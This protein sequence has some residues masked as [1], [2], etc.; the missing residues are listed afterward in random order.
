MA[1]RVCLKDHNINGKRV[2]VTLVETEPNRNKTSEE[3]AITENKSCTVLVS[4]LPEETTEYG[5]HIHFQKKKNGGGEIKT[6]TLVPEKKVATV[7][8]EDIEGSCLPF[9]FRT[10]PKKCFYNTK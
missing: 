4:D 10:Q 9:Y 8:F 5:V 2:E 6:V 1:Q 3:D 7:V